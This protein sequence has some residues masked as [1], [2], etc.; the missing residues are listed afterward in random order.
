MTK[1]LMVA[2]GFSAR[3]IE[4]YDYKSNGW[5]IVAIN[6]GWMACEDLWDFWVKSNDFNG[7]NP[8]NPKPNQQIVKS[9]GPS[10]RLFGGQKAC[11]YS[12]TLNA[13]YWA[14]ANLSP[15][16]IGFLGADMN[17][18]PDDNGY[19]H[20]YGEGND[21]KKRGVPDPDRMVK[22]HGD[23]KPD[24]L[25]R[26]YLR[27]EEEAKKNKC[28]VVNLSRDIDTRLLYQRVNPSSL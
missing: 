10:L 20:I 9:Y 2:S 14:L 17:Y 11:G 13:G 16:V 6:N 24:Y 12:I 25:D 28:R 7:N 22:V 15:T 26:I 21:I 5:K 18:T 8:K 1:V 19:T 3:Q 27:L 23:G 4:D